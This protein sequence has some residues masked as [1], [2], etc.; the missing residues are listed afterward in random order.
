MAALDLAPVVAWDELAGRIDWRQGEH[1]SLIGPTGT[2]KTTLAVE[3]LD[4]RRFVAVLGTKPK[5]KVLARLKRAGWPVVRS[6]PTGY[7]LDQ[8]PRVIVWP[9]YR[10][11][12]DRPA[13]RAELR[14][15]LL[16]A[17]DAGGW[18]VFAD[19]VH[20]LV[21]ELGLGDELRQLWTMGRELNVTVMGATQRPA[22]VP[23]DMFAQ[24][25]HLFL[26]RTSNDVDLRRLGEL[27]TVDPKQVRAVVKALD[28]QSHQ[29]LYLHAGTGAMFRSVLPHG[30]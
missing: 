29:F 5:D 22:H 2:G 24:P 27:G 4:R 20:Y 13:Q 23:L 18:T 1:V 25:T 28:R 16:D 10:S 30:G 17:F 21:R 12:D 19:E 3:L 8:R 26:W 7:A 11:L 15:A 9:R 14:G 6:L